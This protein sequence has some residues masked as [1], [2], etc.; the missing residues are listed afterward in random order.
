MSLRAESV[1]K[2]NLYSNF[3]V[4]PKIWAGNPENR[5]IK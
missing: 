4:I 5:Q 1:R 3:T 2:S